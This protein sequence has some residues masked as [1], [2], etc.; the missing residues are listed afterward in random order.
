[1][2]ERGPSKNQTDQY[3]VSYVDAHHRHPHVDA[4]F[5]VGFR[6]FVGNSYNERISRV[7]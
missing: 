5:V 6:N 1:L 7:N 4:V 3:T 2:R